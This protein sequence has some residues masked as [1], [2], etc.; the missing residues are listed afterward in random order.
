MAERSKVLAPL[1]LAETIGQPHESIAN[2]PESWLSV[3]NQLV[4]QNNPTPVFVMS[5]T[6]SFQ[7]LVEALWRGLPATLRAGLSWGIRFNPPSAKDSLPV[8]V[9]VPEE[10][11]AKWR[12]TAA[13]KLAGEPVKTPET[14]IEQLILNGDQGQDFRDFIENLEVVPDSF[15]SLKLCQ[16]A[17]VQSESLQ[18]ADA[19]KL[20]A[21]LR[22]VRQLQPDPAKAVS[23]KQRVVQALIKALTTGGEQQAMGLRNVPIEPFLEQAERLKQAVEQVVGQVITTSS[24]DVDMQEK[25]LGYLADENPANLEAWWREAAVSVFGRVLAA[26]ST[27]VARVV[28]LGI[29]QNET[30]RNYLLGQV[31]TVSTWEQTLS[32]TVPTSLEVGVADAVA[33]FSVGRKW[34][35]LFA[36]AVGAAYKPAQ[37]L[38]KQVKAEKQLFVSA[39]PRV[40]RLVAKVSDEELVE[41]AIELANNQLLQLAGE[42]CGHNPKLLAPI[43]INQQSWRTIW[44]ESL[45]RTKSITV[46]LRAPAETIEEFLG[47]VATGRANE[48]RPLELIAA[49]AYANVLHLP[50]RAALWDMLPAELRPKFVAATLSTLV[51]EILA[52]SW[53]GTADPVLV[54]AAQTI[55]FATE[56]LGQRRDD[57]AAVLSVNMVLHNLTDG[58]LQDYI[59]NFGIVSSITAAQLGKLVAVQ[60]WKASANAILAK[61]KHND[62][63]RPALHE[64]AEMF[65]RLDKFFNY[66]LFGHQATKDDAWNSLEDVMAKLYEEGPEQGNI[67]KKAGG[68]VGKLTNAQSRGEQ[69][70]A[71]IRLLRHGGGGKHISVATLIHVAL[72]DFKS[73]SELQS[74]ERLLHLF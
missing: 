35:D 10:L 71:A 18:S 40:S 61:A 12:G 2:V 13:I 38:R 27:Q 11:E 32:E 6:H 55:G 15:K 68:D 30:T 36:T 60:R 3:V 19:D 47:A 73:N 74:L 66:N 62:S 34:W 14:P 1:A 33:S 58:Y 45:T 17:Y 59:H 52:G 42:A 56:F 70:T 16:R 57:L 41:L 63:F 7:K 44:S 64:C 8:L 26:N 54:T 29:T 28:W 39:S 20:L 69:W 48:T 22:T 65:G 24:P 50:E 5:E 51:E 46:G 43:D 37:A 67:W 21:L 53:A 31:P 23:F 4:E 72:G 9:N 49:S 25:L